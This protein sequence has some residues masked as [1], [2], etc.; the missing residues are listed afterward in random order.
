MF[1]KVYLREL[2]GS[3]GIELSC[4]IKPC[5]RATCEGSKEQLPRSSNL[6]N[7]NHV[8]AGA[9]D[10]CCKLFEKTFASRGNAEVR[11]TTKICGRQA[12]PMN[13]IER[14][15]SQCACMWSKALS[16]MID[17]YPLLCTAEWSNLITPVRYQQYPP[18]SSDMK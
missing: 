15:R 5:Q 13:T 3:L 6:L 2:G 12:T 9:L 10:F 18:I 4:S 14:D 17:N 11:R 8:L 1:Y 7:V 16:N